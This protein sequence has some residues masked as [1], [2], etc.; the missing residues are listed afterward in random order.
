MVLIKKIQQEKEY[1]AIKDQVG[2]AMLSIAGLPPYFHRKFEEYAQVYKGFG[3]IEGLVWSQSKECFQNAIMNASMS[4]LRYV[5]G[6][7]ESRN[8]AGFPILHAWNLDED[9]RVVD[10]TWDNEGTVYWGVEMSVKYARN[11]MCQSGY[12][13]VFANMF[14]TV[15]KGQINHGKTADEIFLEMREGIAK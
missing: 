13:G 1:Q 2:N 4:N 14:I 5:E 15:R 10:P 6:V 11:Q 12:Y 9:G 7:A 8:L 3:S